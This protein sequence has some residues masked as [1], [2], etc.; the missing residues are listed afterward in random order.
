MNPCLRI[1]DCTCLNPKRCKA[2]LYRSIETSISSVT[3]RGSK[4]LQE[5]AEAAAQKDMGGSRGSGGMR[6]PPAMGRISEE[7]ANRPSLESPPEKAKSSL[8]SVSETQNNPGPGPAE[9]T[10]HGSQPSSGIP[11]T[12]DAVCSLLG[13]S[14]T[15]R[16]STSDA[17]GTDSAPR[18]SDPELR[19]STA[20]AQ[21]SP[22]PKGLGKAQGLPTKKR[23]S[24]AKSSARNVKKKENASS[25]VHTHDAVIPVSTN[26]IFAELLA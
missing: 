4:L 13:N 25:Q 14:A 21:R 26:E 6:N 18:K 5:N 15:A 7:P 23:P 17:S 11:L 2:C 8:E 16:K 12:H 1:C 3:D 20:A 22:G 9:S 24:S 19:G 10:S